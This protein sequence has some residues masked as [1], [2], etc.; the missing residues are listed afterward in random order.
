[1]IIISNNNN[2]NN[3]IIIRVKRVIFYEYQLN[4]LNR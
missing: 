4:S 3:S 1:M 2:N